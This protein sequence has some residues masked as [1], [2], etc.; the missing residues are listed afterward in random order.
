MNE[1][2]LVILV[3]KNDNELGY[4]NKME[5]HQKA[6]LHRAISV[7]LFN[8]KGEWLLQRR[9]SNKYHS[10]GLWTNATCSHPYPGETSYDAANRRLM[11][12]L[13]IKCNLTELFT[14]IYKENLDNDLTEYELDHVFYGFTDQM[15]QVNSDEV[16]DWKY[17]SSEN[18]IHDVNL[19]PDNYTVWFKKIIY[20]V[21]EL[22]KQS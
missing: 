13:G 11:E 22:V 14:F 1:E 9:D 4:M 7:F 6:L 2:P 8:S 18:L 21:H 5:V 19:Y 16:M 20:K 15:P 3:D 17:I 12:E 10:G